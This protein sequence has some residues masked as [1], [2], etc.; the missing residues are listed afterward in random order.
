LQIQH[1]GL[2]FL[3]IQVQEVTEVMDCKE[4]AKL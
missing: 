1:R 4:A 2:S 3:G